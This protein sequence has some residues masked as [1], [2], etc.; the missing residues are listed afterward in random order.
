MSALFI[1]DLH[2]STARPEHLKAFNRLLTLIVGQY[3]SIYILGDLFEE[4]WVGNDDITPPNP[5]ILLKLRSCI[6]S[7]IQVYFIRGNRELL[8]QSDFENISGVTVLP[9]IS[10]VMIAGQS[11]L[12]MH[13]DLL[14]TLDWKY[15]LFRNVMTNSLVQFLIKLLPYSIRTSLAHGIRPGM[16]RHKKT[17]KDTI[18]DVQ[19]ETV[20]DKMRK[21]KTTL[22]VHGHT[23]KPGINNLIIDNKPGQRIVLGDWYRKG[24]ILVEKGNEIELISIENFLQKHSQN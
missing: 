22:L 23:H 10:E 14:C 17:K 5:D 8:L 4:F 2:L 6:E 12:I 20:L 16:S 18:M 7:G 3:D 15:Q 11:A 21:H 9:D 19:P 24:E 13:G 1:S